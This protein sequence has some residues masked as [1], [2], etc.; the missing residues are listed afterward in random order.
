MVRNVGLIDVDRSDVVSLVVTISIRRG[1]KAILAP[2]EVRKLITIL[3]ETLR[4]SP[5]EDDSDLA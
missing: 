3:E 2:V 5:P 4:T 1:N